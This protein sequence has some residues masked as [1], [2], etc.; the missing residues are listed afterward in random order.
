MEKRSIAYIGDEVDRINASNIKASN[1]FVLNTIIYDKLEKGE[2]SEF[3]EFCRR[4]SE[5][6]REVLKRYENS[7]QPKNLLQSICYGLSRKRDLRFLAIEK[8]RLEESLDEKD[9]KLRKY[10]KY[11]RTIGEGC[12][13]L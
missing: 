8:I 12:Y 6:P 5:K 3:D 4:L 10:L 13:S 11:A 7:L 2:K 1:E 9:N